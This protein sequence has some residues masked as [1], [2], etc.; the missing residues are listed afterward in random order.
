MKLLR[1]ARNIRVTDTDRT[2]LLSVCETSVLT[3]YFARSMRP[4]LCIDIEKKI[5]PPTEKLNAN[6]PPKEKMAFQERWVFAGIIEATDEEISVLRV[7][8]GYEIRDLRATSIVEFLMEL[9]M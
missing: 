7:E 9:A 2:L 8:G 5:I 4:M 3:G 6:L 1:I